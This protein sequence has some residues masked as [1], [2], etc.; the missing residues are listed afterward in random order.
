MQHV[1]DTMRILIYLLIAGNLFA[2]A[3]GLLLL[4]APDRLHAWIGQRPHW[5]TLRHFTKPLDV[6]HETDRALLKHPR[7]LGA[8]LLVSAAIILIKGA[9]FVHQF[10]VVEGGRMLARLYSDTH[11][12]TGAWETLWLSMI[13]LLALGALL[14]AAVGLM[15]LFRLD[16]LQG[17]SRIANQWVSTR[18][19]VRPAAKPYFTLDKL[20][21]EQPRAWGATITALALYAAA[22]L[23]WFSRGI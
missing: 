9:M 20:A 15:A 11:W 19:A 14:A 16:L 12:P 5:L 23:I 8:I 4:L 3:I 10:S 21:Q 2:L 1:G 6:P 22:M 17:W 18:Q 7:L 13:I